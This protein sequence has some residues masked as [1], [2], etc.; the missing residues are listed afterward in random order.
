MILY[1]VDVIKRKSGKTIIHREFSLPVNA[2]RERAYLESICS[3]CNVEVKDVET[4]W[5]QV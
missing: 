2:E 3:D 5:G 4:N 1:H